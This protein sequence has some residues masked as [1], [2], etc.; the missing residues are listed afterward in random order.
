MPMG[1]FKFLAIFI[2]QLKFV[3]K[4]MEVM[5]EN[6]ETFESQVTWDE[7]GKPD[8]TIEKFARQ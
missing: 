6:K 3:T 8:I 4:L 5:L 7:L 2:T 1:L